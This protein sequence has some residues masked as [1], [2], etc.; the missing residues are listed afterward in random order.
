SDDVSLDGSG[1][2]GLDGT[3]IDLVGRLQLSEALTQQAGRDL[4]RYTQEEGRVTVPVR[5]TGRAGDLTVTPEAAELLRRAITNKA[6][7]EAGEAIKRGLGSLFG[8]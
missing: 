2:F 3:N 8:R 4:V 5:V 1:S 7:E 6:V